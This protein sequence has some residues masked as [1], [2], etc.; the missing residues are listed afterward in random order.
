MQTGRIT[1]GATG[2][3]G[4]I[5]DERPLAADALA[6]LANT[7]LTAVPLASSFPAKEVCEITHPFLTCLECAF[8]ILPGRQCAVVR[9]CSAVASFCP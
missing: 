7:R 8:L 9:A 4:R 6:A 1:F 3:L 2:V 5:M